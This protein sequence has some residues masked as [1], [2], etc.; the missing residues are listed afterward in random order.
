ML[1]SKVYFGVGGVDMKMS[2]EEVYIYMRIQF[3]HFTGPMNLEK[4]SV[5]VQL[6]GGVQTHLLVPI[7]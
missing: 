4:Q 1:G 3:I 7:Q 5:Q 2:H 6:S